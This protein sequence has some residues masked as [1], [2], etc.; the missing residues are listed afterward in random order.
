MESREFTDGTPAYWRPIIKFLKSSFWAML[1]ACCRTKTK[2]GLKDLK[3]KQKQEY[4]CTRWGPFLDPAGHSHNSESDRCLSNRLLFYD[5]WAQSGHCQR[6]LAA[7]W[8]FD[9]RQT[10]WMADVSAWRRQKARWHW[11]QTDWAPQRLQSETIDAQCWL[12]AWMMNVRE[13]KIKEKMEKEQYNSMDQL[14]HFSKT[15]S[16][17]VNYCFDPL[18]EKVL[19]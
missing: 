4:I 11:T 15:D 9:E 6:C 5:H 18:M 12:A 3:W 19:D 10:F 7:P 14:Q 1:N 8:L 13:Q 16:P 2:S 17:K